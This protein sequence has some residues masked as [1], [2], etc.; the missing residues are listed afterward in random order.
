MFCKVR[1]KEDVWLNSYRI[2]LFGYVGIIIQVDF[3]TNS[4]EQYLRSLIQF[5]DIIYYCEVRA[6][7]LPYFIIYSDF[8]LIVSL[9]ETLSKRYVNFNSDKMNLVDFEQ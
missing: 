1:I 6:D 5:I 8:R 3:F 9:Y 4:I 7:F 2:S